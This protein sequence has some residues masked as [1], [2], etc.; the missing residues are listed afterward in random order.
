M[1]RSE[2]RWESL[3]LG[4]RQ[5][6]ACCIYPCGIYGKRLVRGASKQRGHRLCM[7]LS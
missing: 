4:L 2:T 7:S 6:H 5:G 1:G 3:A